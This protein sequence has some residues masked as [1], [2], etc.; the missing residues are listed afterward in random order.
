MTSL[1]VIK[2][3]SD[4]GFGPSPG[5][6]KGE[7][8]HRVGYG[9]GWSLQPGEPDR[10]GDGVMW[11]RKDSSEEWELSLRNSN[12]LWHH[13]GISRTPHDTMHEWHMLSGFNPGSTLLDPGG[14]QPTSVTSCNTHMT[15]LTTIGQFWTCHTPSSYPC[16]S[17]TLELINPWSITITASHQLPRFPV[18]FPVP[19]LVPVP[20]LCSDIAFLCYPCCTH[21]FPVFQP[22]FWY[23]PIP[24]GYALWLIYKTL[25]LYVIQYV[26]Y[27]LWL[28]LSLST[29]PLVTS[30][31]NLTSVIWFLYIG[32]TSESD[33][34][35]LRN[36]LSLIYS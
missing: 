23:F 15:L 35:S 28:L 12:G 6:N 36:T 34:Q 18:P 7:S 20:V 24:N 31:I 32:N 29:W 9:Q 10:V 19:I 17:S 21:C 27:Q 8:W 22:I 25:T 3:C 5:C 33:F 11:G 16:T 2:G 4:D 14:G 13:S 26:E 1:R 30:D